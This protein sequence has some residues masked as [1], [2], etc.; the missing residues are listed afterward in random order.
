M[1]KIGFSQSHLHK[2]KLLPNFSAVIVNAVVLQT[3]GGR[4]L[5]I[6]IPS[7]VTFAQRRGWTDNKYIMGG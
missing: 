2:K 7:D 3:R 5:S 6:E 1:A 4:L